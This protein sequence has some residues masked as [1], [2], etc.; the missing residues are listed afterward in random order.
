[1]EYVKQEVYNLDGN[2]QLEF[3][4][5][6]TVIVIDKERFLI[7]KQLMMEDA[8]DEDYASFLNIPVVSLLHLLHFSLLIIFFR[9]K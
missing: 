2:T 4:S 6:K 9:R 1:M 5:R 7:C 8:P 3:M